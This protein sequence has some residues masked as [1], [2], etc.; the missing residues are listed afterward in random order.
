[1]VKEKKL[2]MPNYTNLVTMD[3]YEATRQY[4]P[5]RTTSLRNLFVRDMNRRFALLSKAIYTKVVT[6]D[7]FGL[8]PQEIVFNAEQYLFPRSSEKVAAF[9]KWLD[10]QVGKG[11][12]SIRIGNRS[13]L[14][15]F[16]YNRFI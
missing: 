9:M 16:I 3:V 10:E 6:E 5:T 8:K 14:A 15:K 4:D 2:K 12:L 1:V 13:S 11:L 7:C